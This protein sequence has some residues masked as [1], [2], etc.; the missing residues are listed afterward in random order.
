[1]SIAERLVADFDIVSSSST[2]VLSRG[3]GSFVSF[4]SGQETTV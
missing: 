2:T 3:K 1:M 4:M